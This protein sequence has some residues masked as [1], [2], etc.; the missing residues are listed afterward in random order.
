VWSRRERWLG[1]AVRNAFGYCVRGLSPGLR[2]NLAAFGR[3]ND[4]RRV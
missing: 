4:P 3:H 1:A 2:S